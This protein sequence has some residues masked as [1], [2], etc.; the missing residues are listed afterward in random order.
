MTFPRFVRTGQPQSPVWIDGGNPITRGLC[1]GIDAASKR[2]FGN[3]NRS[4]ASIGTTPTRLGLASNFG[5]VSTLSVFPQGTSTASITMLQI[6]LISANTA[7]TCPFSLSHNGAS[8]TFTIEHSDGITAGKV[9]GRV[10][11]GGY[12][13]C[14]GSTTLPVGSVYVAVLRHTNGVGQALWLNGLKDAATTSAT[15]ATLGNTYYGAYTSIS[16]YGLL[17][18]VWNRA[19]S[20]AEIKSLSENPWQIFQP[21]NRAI[22]VPVVASV[23][24]SNAPRYFHRTQSGQA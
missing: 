16:E 23:G 14:G 22:V 15:G 24:A 18:A 21:T 5:N 13:Y 6:G 7:Q 4:L 9:R 12:Q 11:I 20:D 8:N 10:Y 2:Y 17:N 1:V 3:S 19:L